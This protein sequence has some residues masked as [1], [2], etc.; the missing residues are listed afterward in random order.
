MKLINSTL[1]ATFKNRPN[2]FLA[3]VILN[4]D[5]KGKKELLAHVPD[6]GRLKELLVPNAEV[7]LI[8]SSNQNRKTQFSLIGVKTGNIWI[9]IDSMI[10][11]RLFNEEYQKI[12]FFR[13]YEIIRSEYTFG[14]SR[15][16]FFMRNIRTNK[17]ALIEI[18]SVTLV[19]NGKAL[20]P[21]APT[22]RGTKHVNELKNA[23]LQGYDA[24]IVFIVK[25]NDVYSFSPN[26]LIDVEFSHALKD[27]YQSGVHISAVKCLYDPI[28]KNELSILEEIPI[29][30]E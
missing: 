9:N 5:N 21:D 6:P 4:D 24:S 19:K 17:Q 23:I 2:R 3:E 8:E 27:A 28:H 18:K 16:D 1:I 20:F 25:R 13:D 7:I 30:L 26:E 10:S 22:L 29:S 15:F 14:K 11:N 12:A